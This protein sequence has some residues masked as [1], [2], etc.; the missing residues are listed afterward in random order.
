MDIRVIAAEA[1]SYLGQTNLALET[2]EPIIKSDQEY[3]SLAALNA[4]DFMHEAGHV[5]LERILELM[6]ETQFKGISGRMADY[7][8]A[9]E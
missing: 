3:V 2:L 6:G 7:F 8:Q 1:M 5:S 9:T 4:L